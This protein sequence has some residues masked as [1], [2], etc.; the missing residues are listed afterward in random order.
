[1]RPRTRLPTSAI[2][3]IAGLA[4]G[5]SDAGEF[6]ALR[7]D[8]AL[9]RRERDAL[10]VQVEALQQ[11]EGARAT[12]PAPEADEDSD[13][14]PEAAQVFDQA[15]LREAGFPEVEIERL[16]ERWDQAELD[17]LYLVDQAKREGW[18]RSQRFRGRM[19]ELREDL[20]AELCDEGYDAL[21]YAAGR[22]NRVVVEDVL[23]GSAAQ[24]AGIESGDALFSYA[25]RRLFATQELI[26][27]TSA[28]E[29]GAQT[30]VRV[31]RN[32][33]EIRLFVPRG[34]LGVRVRRERRL[35][36]TLRWPLACRGRG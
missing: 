2:A 4:A 3:T 21:L 7:R 34:P 26:R 36:D 31:D 35:P 5:G 16:R 10:A 6:A 23:A 32:G 29:A 9:A 30:E 33:E 15:W 25:E 12:P 17:R 19:R 13:E 18:H 27:T 24:Q 8:L 1:M 14:E 11:A 20:R 22:G 28:G